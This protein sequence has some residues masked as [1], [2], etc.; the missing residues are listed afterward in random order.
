ME[1]LGIEESWLISVQGD[2]SDAC[3]IDGRTDVAR[4]PSL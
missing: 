3:G 1:L 2:R 4:G